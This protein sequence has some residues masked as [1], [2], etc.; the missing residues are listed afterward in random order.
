MCKYEKKDVSSVSLDELSTIVR[1]CH[2][3]FADRSIFRLPFPQKEGSSAS[4]TL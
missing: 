3:I 1:L 2:G 4:V